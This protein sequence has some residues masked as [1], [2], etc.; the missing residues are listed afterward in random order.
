MGV[1]NKMYYNVELDDNGNPYLEVSCEGKYSDYLLY[2]KSTG[3]LY[4]NSFMLFE[5]DSS[6]EDDTIII[7]GMDKVPLDCVAIITP[8]QASEL[9]S[10]STL[11]K[12]DIVKDTKSKIIPIKE[13]NYPT[14][15]KILVNAIM[16]YGKDTALPQSEHSKKVSLVAALNKI[17]QAENPREISISKT[18]DLLRLFNIPLDKIFNK[19]IL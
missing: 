16:I 7:V 10:D 8:Q 13:G 12:V 9:V 15:T 4:T 18:M 1:T 6:K 3:K 17:A 11:A 14:F 19:E 5:I 2:D